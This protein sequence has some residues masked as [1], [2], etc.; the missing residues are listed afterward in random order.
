MACLLLLDAAPQMNEPP[1]LQRGDMYKTWQSCYASIRNVS[2]DL[3]V[4][5]MDTGQTAENIGKAKGK[6]QKEK[7][8]KAKGKKKEKGK[9]KKEKGNMFLTH[10]RTHAHALFIFI[11]SHVHMHIRMHIHMHIHRRHRPLLCDGQ[12]A[13]RGRHTPGQQ[14]DTF[15]FWA[16]FCSVLFCSVLFCSVLFFTLSTVV[17]SSTRFT[18][19]HKPPER[20]CRLRRLVNHLVYTC[21]AWCGL[22]TAY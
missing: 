12:V 11:H 18:V 1:A 10:T 19:T 15:A 20:R 2:K 14:P 5:I 21:G 3:A 8:E 16:L 6:R 13:H 22:R 7:K 17:L 4:G 9:R